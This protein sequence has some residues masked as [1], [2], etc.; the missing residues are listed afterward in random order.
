[1]QGLADGYFVL[2]ATIGDFLAGTKADAVDTARVE[3]KDAEK[4]AAARLDQ[5]LAIKGKRTVDSFHRELGRIMWDECGMARSK[6]GLEGA[7]ARI[8]ALREEFWRNVNVVGSSGEPNDVLERAGRVADFLE[9]G[10]LMCRDA[11]ARDESCG[12]HFRVEHQT[13]EGEA[14]RDDAGFAAAFVWEYGNGAGPK[15]HREEL[16]FEKVKLAERSYK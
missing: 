2:P 6:E 12:G 5:L 7:I 11:L 15:L 14:R 1:M 16:K 4:Q 10:E 9:F 13:A 3:F 8:Q